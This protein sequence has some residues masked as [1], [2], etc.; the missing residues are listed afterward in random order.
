MK[1]ATL[2][3]ILGWARTPILAKDFSACGDILRVKFGARP[4]AKSHPQKKQRL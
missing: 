4:T 3:L 2:G 1:N